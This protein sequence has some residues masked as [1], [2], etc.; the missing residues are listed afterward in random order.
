MRLPLVPLLF[1][2]CALLNGN[3]AA[4]D[5][6]RN[7]EFLGFRSQIPE[8]WQ[9]NTPSSSMRAAQVM[10]PGADPVEMIVYYFGPGQG[11]SAEA[12][13]ARWQGQFRP[14]DGKPVEAMVDHF[15]TQGGFPVTW[16]ELRGDYARGVGMGPMGEYKPDRI[17]IAAVTETPK[18]NLYIQFHGEAD[19]VAKHKE[20]FRKF[21][22]NLAP[23]PEQF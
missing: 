15:Q 19:N 16:V 11:G 21:V 3:A 23:L 10:V 2:L 13:I 4:S 17:L 18:G 7:L 5:A 22:A 1:A 14:V 12:N 8:D 9:P 20:K 6:Q